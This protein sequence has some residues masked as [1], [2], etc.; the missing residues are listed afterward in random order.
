MR[1]R[2]PAHWA[3]RAYDPARQVA[4]AP[5]CGDAGD[6]PCCSRLDAR[7]GGGG[8]GGEEDVFA[9]TND[10]PVSLLVDLSPTF[11]LAHLDALC[12][13]LSLLE[14]DLP[15]IVL[16]P[17]ALTAQQQPEAQHALTLWA[18]AALRRLLFAYWR[19]GG[20][21]VRGDLER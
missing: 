18:L 11:N 2:P 13:P 21:L 5:S 1:P 10:A 3:A 12:S 14:C 17:S 19:H 20:E 8:G 16:V 4:R 6:R 7:G 9:H 15:Q